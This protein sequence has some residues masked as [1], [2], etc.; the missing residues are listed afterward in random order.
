MLTARLKS[1]GLVVFLDVDLPTLA[2]RI[3][4]Y[5]TRG[6]A[7]RADQDFAGMFRE[8]S[9]LYTKYADITITAAGLTY[10]EVCARI[11]ACVKEKN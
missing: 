3:H 1:G 5:S 4:D 9:A 8:R 10:E 6:L 7:K 11:V 2:S